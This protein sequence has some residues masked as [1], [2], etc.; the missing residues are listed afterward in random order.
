[1]KPSAAILRSSRKPLTRLTI[2]S[3]GLLL[4]LFLGACAATR[5]ATQPENAST[6]SARKESNGRENAPDN[7]PYLVEFRRSL[8]Y[9]GQGRPDLAQKIL[10]GLADSHKD[11]G[12][13]LN[14][15]GVA[16]KKQGM[17][18][19]A[20]ETYRHAIE[21]KDSNVEAHYNLGILYREQGDFKKAEEEYKHAVF[22]D[23]NFA[24][25]HYNLG[26]LYDL[27]LNQPEDALK[28]YEEYKRLAG[29]NKELEVWIKDL[30][31]RTKPADSKGE[32]APSGGVQ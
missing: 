6:P 4:G 15:L 23:P 31:R 14:A 3:L 18:D 25:A 21:L 13:I 32:A 27:Y 11:S 20:V 9:I 28:Q 22:L 7:R 30:T 12:E 17:T 8:E 10:E 19:K 16:Y 26:I 2:L 5:S 1:V 29:G 24:Q